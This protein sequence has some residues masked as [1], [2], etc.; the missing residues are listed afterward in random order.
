LVYLGLPW[1][2]LVYLGLP[3]FTL[4]HLGSP[5]FTLVY[6]GLPWF[7]LV[8]LGLPWFTLVYLCLPWFTF[9]YKINCFVNNISFLS[10]SPEG[11]VLEN[12]VHTQPWRP[13]GHGAPVSTADNQEDQGQGQS[14]Q[15]DSTIAGLS[16]RKICT[17]FRLEYSIFEARHGQKKILNPQS[18]DVN[19]YA[20]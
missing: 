3:W 8:Y 4:V 11:E 19:L 15:V 18:V 20:R 12:T 17:Y 7:T 6:L 13:H 1:F 9:V 2:T 5:W 10:D 16:L 14:A